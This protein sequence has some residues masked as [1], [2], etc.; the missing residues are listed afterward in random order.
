MSYP[1]RINMGDLSRSRFRPDSP[2]VS[3]P[4]G[5]SLLPIRRLRWIQNPNRRK[6]WVA[7]AKKHVE[8][9]ALGC[10]VECS[11]TAF[12]TTKNSGAWLRRTT[13]AAVPKRSVAMLASALPIYCS[14]GKP[15]GKGR[16]CHDSIAEDRGSPPHS[17]RRCRSVL[18][19]C[20]IIFLSPRREGVQA[21]AD[22]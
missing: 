13:G 2:P 1:K 10:P 16:S 12:A 19:C 17:R 3:R 4:Y 18:R 15:A 14:S 7:P 8:T 21:H 11:S 9:A 20:T 5:R 22:A 6:R